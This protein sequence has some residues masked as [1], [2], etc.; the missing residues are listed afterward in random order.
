MTAQEYTDN[1]LLA[2]LDES[3][4]AEQAA[5]LE[6]RLR[7]DPELLSR[8]SDLRS[9]EEAGVHSLGA[10][11][12]RF[13]LSCPTREQWGQWLLGVLD[14]P[15]SQYFEFHLKRVGCRYCAAN[16]EDLK[17]QAADVDRDRPQRRRRFFQTS[18]GRMPKQ[19]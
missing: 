18:V 19:K 2:F 6:S 13:R 12:R 5:A 4:P 1:Q 14:E 8:L 3:L 11:W 16:L 15:T 9:R 7:S 10:I 17:R